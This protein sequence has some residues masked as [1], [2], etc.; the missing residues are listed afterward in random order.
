M[1]FLSDFVG[2]TMQNAITGGAPASTGN[3]D[4][5]GAPAPILPQINASPQTKQAFSALTT[6]PPPQP[7]PQQML[8]LS[9]QMVQPAQTPQLAPQLP[10]NN[11]NMQQALAQRF[12]NGRQ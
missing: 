4:T 3:A 2:K 10:L 12:S 9:P 1:G 8:S 11:V 5:N 6:P 7:P